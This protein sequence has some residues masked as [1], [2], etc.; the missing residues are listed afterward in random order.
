MF[1]GW[2]SAQDADCEKLDTQVMII[3]R[4]QRFYRSV[5]HTRKLSCFFHFLW[6]I[7]V[8]SGA[9]LCAAHIRG[10]KHTR[11]RSNSTVIPVADRVPWMHA[12]HTRLV[13]LRISSLRRGI[14]WCLKLQP[15]VGSQIMRRRHSFQA[16]AWMTKSQWTN[17]LPPAAEEDSCNSRPVADIK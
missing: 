12:A 4:I 13:S 11:W 2:G 6:R 9:D 8:T 14:L 5:L 3:H 17:A 15:A 10:L 7:H 16:A 1:D